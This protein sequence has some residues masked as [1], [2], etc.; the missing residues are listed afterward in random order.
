MTPDRASVAAADWFLWPGTQAVFACLNR[1]GFEARVVGGA[2]R[3]ALLGQPVNEVD[4]ATTAT[5][6]DVVRL[7]AEAGIKTVPT[8]D[9]AWHRDADRMRRPVRGH[10]AA[11]R[12]RYRWPPRDRR[13]WHRLG[14][15]RALGAD[16]TMNA[17]YADAGGRVH[18]PLGGLGDLRAGRVRF[19]RRSGSAHPRGLLADLALFQVQR[20]LCGGRFDPEGIRAAIRERVRPSCGC[21]A[22][23]CGQGAI[24]HPG[25]PARR[26]GP[27]ESGRTGLLPAH[28]RRCAA[29]AL[30]PPLRGRGSAW[31]RAGPG[32][33]ARGAGGVRGGRMPGG[34]AKS[35]GCPRTRRKS[36]RR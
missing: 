10:G 4:F 34:L 8:G 31:A 2:V 30:Q 6:D 33:A 20:G 13:L 12:C 21:R 16:F 27:S 18:D 14:G 17:L 1:D 23:A 29:H 32:V 24:A 25:V 35:C 9:R 11:P 3:N 7:A 26:R 22:S 36:W 15:G 19:V 28:R 5:P